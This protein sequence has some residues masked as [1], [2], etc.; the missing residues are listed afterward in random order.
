MLYKHHSTAHKIPSCKF[1]FKDLSN[2]VELCERQHAECVKQL[3]DEIFSGQFT[4]E[5]FLVSDRPGTEQKI[6]ANFKM[7]IE[8][9]G[10]DSQTKIH[11]LLRLEV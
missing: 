1:T 9:F 2:L 10:D 6:D 4:Q 7:I 5:G 11:V 3:K 8:I